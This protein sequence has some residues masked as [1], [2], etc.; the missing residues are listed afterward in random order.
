MI[1]EAIGKVQVLQIPEKCNDEPNKGG[2][3]KL[4]RTYILCPSIEPVKAKPIET[5]HVDIGPMTT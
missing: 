5:K 3:E 2:A 4:S 1:A